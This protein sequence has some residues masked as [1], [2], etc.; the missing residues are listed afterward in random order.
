MTE[1]SPAAAIR[2]PVCEVLAVPGR[3]LLLLGAPAGTVAAAQE[4]VQAAGQLNKTP[5][6]WAPVGAEQKPS[7]AA[8]V[9]GGLW[10]PVGAHGSTAPPSSPLVCSSECAG[11]SACARFSQCQLE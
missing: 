1:L 8:G 9:F 11:S 10:M 4:A 2:P 5:R 7:L 3:G 6:L